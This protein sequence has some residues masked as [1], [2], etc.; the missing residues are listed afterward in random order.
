MDSK[1]PRLALNIAQIIAKERFRR[2]EKESFFPR[3]LRIEHVSAVIALPSL[4]K[5]T[6]LLA[7]DFDTR[8]LFPVFLSKQ[9]TLLLWP[10]DQKNKRTEEYRSKT[11]FDQIH[12]RRFP[13]SFPFISPQLS[14]PS[15]RFPFSRSESLIPSITLHHR[16]YFFLLQNYFSFF[17]IESLLKVDFVSRISICTR[18]NPIQHFFIEKYEVEPR[19]LGELWILN[20]LRLF[21]RI[22]RYL[23]WRASRPYIIRSR[24]ARNVDS[25]LRAGK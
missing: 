23:G 16:R 22:P 2:R 3:H 6:S 1:Y 4:I 12:L 5:K 10:H 7:K 17:N 25:R 21:Y 20:K 14:S 18:L 9:R 11:S 15:M 8:A 13:F 24:I 19:V